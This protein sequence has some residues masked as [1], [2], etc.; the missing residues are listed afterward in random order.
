MTAPSRPHDRHTPRVEQWLLTAAQR[1]DRR[2]EEELLRRYEPLVR[3]LTARLQLPPGGERDDVA[4]EA[5]IGL[6]GAIRDWRPGHR[7][8]FS[9][10]AARC[11]KNRALTAL[12]AAGAQRQQILSTARRFDT[13]VAPSDPEGGPVRTLDEPRGTFADPEATVLERELLARVVAALP[14]LS[15]K[16]RAVYRGVIN[17][18][19]H[20]ALAAALGCSAKAVTTAMR[21]ARRKLAA[22][23]ELT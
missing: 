2:A 6:L 20:Q 21:R 1:G 7:V 14:S 13:P 9:T 22:A 10:F 8:P 15:E 11:I 23:A 16:E 19:T 5:R 4:Q 17:G 18:F 3:A 12:D